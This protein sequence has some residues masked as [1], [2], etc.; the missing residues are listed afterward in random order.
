LTFLFSSVKVYHIF[1]GGHSMKRFQS[2]LL[3]VAASAVFLLSITFVPASVCAAEIRV[4]QDFLTIQDAISS[5]TFT[6]G[7]TIVVDRGI[8]FG[9]IT[10]PNNVTLKGTE[11]AQTFLSGNG[12]GPVMTG[13]GTLGTG[14]LS[15][16]GVVNIHNF[17]FINASSGISILNNASTISIT[18]NVFQVGLGG[19]AVTIQNSSL[20]EVANNTFYQNGTALTCDL[21]IRIFNNIFSINNTAIADTAPSTNN[22]E[23]N[24][25]SGNFVSGPTGTNTIVADP[26]FVFPVNHDFHLKEK[27][28]CIGA[29]TDGTD[30][31][32]YGGAS[33]DTIPFPVKGLS[34]GSVTPSAASASIGLTWSSNLSYLVTNS[35]PSLAGSYGLYLGS[36]SGDYTCTVATCGVASPISL[37]SLT[38]EALSNTIL[39]GLTFSTTPPSAP[40][41]VQSSPRDS[42]LVL[43]WS[44]VPGATGYKVHYGISSPDENDPIDAGNTTSYELSGLTNG[45][46]YFVAVSAYA[47]QQYYFAITARNHTDTTT[48]Q[49]SVHSTET[50]TNIGPTRESGLSAVISDFPEPVITY[51]ALPGSGGHCFIATAAY[52]YYSAPEVQA[53]RVFRDRY[54]LSSAPGRMFVQWYY[55]RGPIAAAFLNDHP[56]YKPLVRAALM[57]A[58]GAALFMTGT[59]TM[60]KTCVFLVLGAALAFGLIRKRLSRMGGL[61]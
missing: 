57:P 13:N 58:V 31:G 14:V 30:V 60:F 46:K 24:A 27:S 33:A 6:P 29:G 1:S 32:A 42:R 48:I 44:A 45:Q 38:T 16:L 2:T 12:S 36:A 53:L 25:F 54:L 55:R 34:I 43:T 28:L 4:P 61:L 40:D 52:G 9:P 5:A 19:A 26:L 11:T 37:P 51:P 23:N 21:D 8:Y 47:R 7:D 17:T 35:D 59:S 18:N 41:T 20:T 22:I 15:T 56:G 39:N 10:L 50:S 3:L 49:E